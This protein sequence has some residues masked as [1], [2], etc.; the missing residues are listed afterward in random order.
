MHSIFDPAP[1]PSGNH[2]IPL[3][4]FEYLGR[5]LF[6]AGSAACTFGIVHNG[7][8]AGKID[9]VLG[10]VPGAE[11]AFDAGDLTCPG[12]LLPVGIPVGTEDQGPLLIPGDSLEDLLGTFG[13][14]ET[15]AGTFGVIYFGKAVVLQA[16]GAELAFFYAVPKTKAA[17]GA[18]LGPPDGKLCPPA[19]LQ[20]RVQSLCHRMEA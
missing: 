4:N 16:Q 12:N 14:A 3:K 13:N 10:A 9:A 6:R 7:D 8:Q 1:T 2:Y 18:E 15:A 19:G 5:A 11:A 17:P 20:T